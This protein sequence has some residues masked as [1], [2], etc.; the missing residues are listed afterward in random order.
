MI[1]TP[2]SVDYSSPRIDSINI[3]EHGVELIAGTNVFTASG[4]PSRIP[5]VR[6]TGNVVNYLTG[7]FIASSDISHGEIICSLPTGFSSF[8]AG[9]YPAVVD[10]L[11]NWGIRDSGTNQNLFGI[12]FN[13]S[14]RYV[15]VGA[16]P[17]IVLTS[18]DTINWVQSTTPTTDSM[19]AVTC[20]PVTFLYVAVGDTGTGITSADGTTWNLIANTQAADTLQDITFDNS[21]YVAVGGNA[22]TPIIVTSPDATT[23]TSRAIPAGITARINGVTFGNGV[24]VIV[25]SGGEVATSA[26]GITWTDHGTITANSLEEVIFDGTQ[27]I[28]VGFAATVFTSPDGINWTDMSPNITVNIPDF[29]CIATDGV[30]YIIGGLNLSGDNLYSSEDLITYTPEVNPITANTS[31]L[32]QIIFDGNEFVMV[33][34]AGDILVSN[35]DASIFTSMITISGRDIIANESISVSEKISFDGITFIGKSD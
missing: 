1:R 15:V 9:S 27:F 19:L 5:K 29:L 32:Q 11:D 2:K 14:T 13:E 3:E 16:I 24:F 6:T 10:N 17:N 33:A 30:Q 7:E 20:H 12:I 23:W 21:L 35:F 4:N 25:T 8:S 34:T 22:P 28:T 26:D 31:I 18:V